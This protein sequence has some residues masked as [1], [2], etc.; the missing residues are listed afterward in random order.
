[1]LKIYYSI[2]VDAIDKSKKANNGQWKFV[3][4]LFLSAF[5]SI[6]L[7]SIVML[8]ENFFPNLYFSIYSREYLKKAVDIKMEAI[9]LYFLPS[10]IFNYFL[11]IYKKK[12]VGLIKMYK[13]SDG[14]KMIQFI[15]FSLILFII[16]NVSKLV[17]N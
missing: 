16:G 4:I 8:L 7:M 12:Y 11:I 10:I 14:K 3:V 17:L 1:M 13:P 5:L 2:C 9:I 6:I 15:L